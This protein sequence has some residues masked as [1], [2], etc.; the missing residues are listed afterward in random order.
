[1][2]IN[3]IEL[4]LSYIKPRNCRQVTFQCMIQLLLKGASIDADI[5]LH[6]QSTMDKGVTLSN[7]LYIADWSSDKTVISLSSG[8]GC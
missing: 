2:K 3:N 5:F 6:T 8:T 4:F 1:M 7:I